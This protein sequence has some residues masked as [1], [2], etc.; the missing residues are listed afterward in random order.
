MAYQLAIEGKTIYCGLE[1]SGK[2]YLLAK[3]FDECLKRNFKWFRKYGIKRILA[4]NFPINPEYQE[5]IEESGMVEFRRWERIE[6]IIE[7]EGCDFFIDEM[8]LYFDAQVW[9]DLSL[10]IKKWITQGAKSG[11]HVYG[12]CQDFSQVAKSFRLVTNNLY[13]VTKIIGNRRPGPNLPPLKPL[14]GIGT[15]VW[16]MGRIRPMNPLKFDDESQKFEKESI[17]TIRPF[18]FQEKYTRLFN[19]NEK[20]KASPII[21]REHKTE[22]CRQHG[23][24]CLNHA[25][26][27]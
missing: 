26:H 9:K 17:F 20:L 3:S 19:T 4:P 27:R 5:F 25:V 7:W 13:M 14:W 21:F 18:I 23:E 12:A 10:E 8:L 11:N 16:G 22:I 6:E 2:S 15:K 1:S 24:K